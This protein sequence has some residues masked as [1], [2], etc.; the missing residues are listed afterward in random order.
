MKRICQYAVLVLAA[1]TLGGCSIYGRYSRPEDIETDGLFGE[2]VIAGDSA[3]IADIGWR[4]FFTDPCLQALIDKALSDNIDLK[5]AELRIKE[6]E[7][8][9]KTARLSY[10][11]S[12]SFAP[13]GSLSTYNFDGLAKNYQ[14]PLNISWNIDV[15]GRLYNRKHKARVAYEQSKVNVQYVHTRL[16]ASIANAYYTLLMLDSQLEVSR[17]TA[18]NWKENVRIMRAMKEAGM[19]NEA[20]V[21]QTEANSCSIEASL[22]DLYRQIRQVENS[23]SLMLGDA[24]RSIPR[25]RLADQKLYDRLLVGVPVQLLSNR[26]DVRG[27]ELDLAQAFY[28]TNLARAAFYPSLT[29]NGVLGWV[30]NSGSALVNPGKFLLSFVGSLVQPI[31]NAGANRAQLKIAESQQEQA[32]LAFAQALL[33]AGRE[34][35]DALVQCRTAEDK[36]DVRRRQIAALES[37][38]SSTQ[39][40][41]RHGDATYLEVLTAQQTLLQAQL[42][43][44]ADR[45][46]GI[47]GMINLYLSLGGGRE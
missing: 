16:V 7:A 26:P 45:F 43:Q 35:N 39:Q 14:L 27:A 28:T 29:L 23:L 12:F 33:N 44:I 11:P 9:L 2:G 21:S 34:V 47:Q 42:S 30:N 10:Y 8:A 40:L 1:A 37:A 20:S 18:A 17:T 24:P 15:A 22:F 6:A 36:T 25:G 19:T 3:T 5:T 4:D 38:V 13:Q 31:F 46:E 41:M 32:K